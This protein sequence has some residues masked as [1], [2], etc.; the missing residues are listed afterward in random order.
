MFRAIATHPK[1]GTVLTGEVFYQ[2]SKLYNLNLYNTFDDRAVTVDTDTVDIIHDDGVFHEYEWRA[3]PHL[4]LHTIRDPR[5]IMVS[6]VFY[7][8]KAPAHEASIFVPRKYWK[9]K[10]Y[11]DM[12]RNSDTLE[13]KLLHTITYKHTTVESLKNWDYTDVRYLNVRFEDLCDPGQYQSTW[14]KCLD[15][16]EYTGSHRD[17]LK[18]IA[19][20]TSIHNNKPKD[21]HYR[22]AKPA[23][24]KQYFTERTTAVFN[25]R[26]TDV[27]ELL[28]YEK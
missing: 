25:E 6:S 5:D 22:S 19:M 17:S 12:L 13:E 14:D 15:H 2:F 3:L 1:A 7:Y 21:S 28:G 18:Q 20:D 4:G 9:G 23:Q 11:L 8:E 10:T 27:I 16:L 24:Y 26:Y